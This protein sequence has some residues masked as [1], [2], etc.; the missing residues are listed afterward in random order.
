MRDAIDNIKLEILS[1]Q[2]HRFPNGS[3]GAA[4]DVLGT[5]LDELGYKPIDRV[6]KICRVPE[7]NQSHTWLEHD[8]F[9][10][11]ITADQLNYAPKIE[12]LFGTKN[13]VV[14]TEDVSD[15]YEVFDYDMGPEDRRPAHYQLYHR[16][17]DEHTAKLIERDYLK[18]E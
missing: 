14:V 18:I 4:A 7:Q 16:L 3:C 8:K 12:N 11:D 15:W 1:A 9:L 17:D 10:I 2:F 6:L 13:K 5:Y